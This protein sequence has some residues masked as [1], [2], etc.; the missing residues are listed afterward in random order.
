MKS[1][2]VLLDSPDGQI[3]YFPNFFPNAD[4]LL[5]R[6]QEEI[7]FESEQILMFGKKITVPRLI[8]WHGE[9]NTLS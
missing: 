1:K 9:P 6:I 2:N 5:I 4:E 8:A 7:N 3:F